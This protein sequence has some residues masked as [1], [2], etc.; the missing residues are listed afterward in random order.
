[1][2]ESAVLR[3]S[4]SLTSNS[5]L[6]VVKYKTQ[7]GT[8]TRQPIRSVNSSPAFLQ[9]RFAFMIYVNRILALRILSVRIS[10]NLTH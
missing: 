6:Y 4:P 3:R 7:F 5:G 2:F 9:L 1:M 8:Q 10:Y